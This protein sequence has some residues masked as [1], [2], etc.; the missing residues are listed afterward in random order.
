MDI[1]GRLEMIV[2]ALKLMATGLTREIDLPRPCF[3]YPNGVMVLDAKLSLLR[4][5]RVD[6]RSA[7][8]FSPVLKIPS[9]S[10]ALLEFLLE[11]LQC[12]DCVLEHQRKSSYYQLT[13]NL[14]YHLSACALYK[15]NDVALRS[16]N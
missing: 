8:Y 15:Q 16:D 2:K 12:Q 9:G 1:D 4:C 11:G 5:N 3:M 13:Y 10:D 7:Y 14:G 6:S